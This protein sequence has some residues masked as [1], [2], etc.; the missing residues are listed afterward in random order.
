MVQ[1]D[2]V[3]DCGIDRKGLSNGSDVIMRLFHESID[4]SLA[5]YRLKLHLYIDC[6]CS[7]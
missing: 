5:G 3:I 2:E 4:W 1:R 7:R 6:F